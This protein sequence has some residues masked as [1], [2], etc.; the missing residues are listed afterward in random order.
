M[1]SLMIL[2]LAAR[3][4]LSGKN[5]RSRAEVPC[6]RKDRYQRGLA[7]NEAKKRPLLFAGLEECRA[8]EPRP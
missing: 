1:R 6:S 5:P 2:S 7:G 8:T 3:S 4:G